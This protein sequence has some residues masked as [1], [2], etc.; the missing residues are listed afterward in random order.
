MNLKSASTAKK[1]DR[2][3][4]SLPF[5]IGL[6]LDDFLLQLADSKKGLRAH[7]L[8]PIYRYILARKGSQELNCILKKNIHTTEASK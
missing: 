2:H 6:T 3:Y 5:L 4:P 7:E 8:T 1:E